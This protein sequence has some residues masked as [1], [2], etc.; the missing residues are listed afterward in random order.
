MGA[1]PG[2]HLHIDGDSVLHRLPAH[3]KVV[4]LLAFALTTV[5]V[6]AP[7]WWPLTVAMLTG[8]GLVALTGVAWRYV[9]PRLLIEVPF[10]LF[11][12]VLP[13]VASGPRMALGPLQVS[14][15]GLLSAWALAAKGTAAVLA[16]TAFAVT[17]TPRDLVVGLQRL[18]VPDTLVG[19]LSFMVRYAAVVGDEMRRMRIARE[20][21]GFRAAS[22]RS[23]PTLGRTLGALFVRSFERGERVHVSM[24]SRGWTG[25]FP[26]F[27]T[28]TAG[29]V[30]WACAALPALLVALTA[31][32]A[33][34]S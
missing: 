29:L 9:W 30:D 14:E 2:L 32:W 3:A 24:V 22:L 16:A 27:A 26:T 5:A 21:R 23:W 31:A 11:A 10:L 13:F 6:P 18:H 20:S 34:A 1:R 33:L 19:I 28:A 4:G 15:V 25:T 8:C 12:A 7:G 17:T